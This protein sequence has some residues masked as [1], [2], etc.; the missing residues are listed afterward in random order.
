MPPFGDLS[1]QSP[2]IRIK[3]LLKCDAMRKAKRTPR[4]SVVD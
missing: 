2:A 4:M 1:A 3:A